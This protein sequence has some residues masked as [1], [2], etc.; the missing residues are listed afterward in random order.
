M[1][2]VEQKGG[3]KENKGKG[4]GTRKQQ[5]QHDGEIHKSKNHQS[6]LV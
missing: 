6:K 3:K 2:C 4:G 5:Q 1:L